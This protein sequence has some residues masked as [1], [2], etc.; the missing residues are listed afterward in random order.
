MAE[1]RGG[2]RYDSVAARLNLRRG[3][4]HLRRVMRIFYLIVTVL[5][6]VSL[7]L[8]EVVAARGVSVTP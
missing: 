2:I 8:L 6:I 5:L 1:A 7:G 3:T 4:G